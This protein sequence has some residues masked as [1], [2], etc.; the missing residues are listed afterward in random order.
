LRGGH[1]PKRRTELLERFELDPTKKGRSYSKGNR[2]KVALVAALASDAPLLLLDEPTT[3][4]DPVMERVF[5][6][7]LVRIRDERRTVLLS[8]Q[9]SP[10]R[11]LCDR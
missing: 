9:S 8:S 6:D 4:L 2:Q 11:A 5:Q 10:G 3:G 7:E 1:D